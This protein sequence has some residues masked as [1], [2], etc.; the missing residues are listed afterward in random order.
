MPGCG[1][2]G[3]GGGGVEGVVLAGEVHF[4]FRPWRAGAENFPVHAAGLIAEI[5]DPPVGGVSK[6]VALDA[7]E[8]AAHTLGDVGDCRRKRR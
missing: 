1:S 4:E 6:S 7:A 3:G 2:E 5:A 8:G